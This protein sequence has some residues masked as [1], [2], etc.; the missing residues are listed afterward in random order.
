MPEKLKAFTNPGGEIVKTRYLIEGKEYPQIR[1]VQHGWEVWPSGKYK[2]PSIF[3]TT[4][5][6]VAAYESYHKRDQAINKEHNAKMK[7]R[8]E[9]K[10]KKE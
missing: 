2:L 1:R 3:L 4:R 6:A 9:Q 8:R 5:Q 7:L 10:K